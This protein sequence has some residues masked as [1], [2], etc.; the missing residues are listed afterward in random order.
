MRLLIY[1]DMMLNRKRLRKAFFKEYVGHLPA[2]LIPL[3]QKI[4]TLLLKNKKFRIIKSNQLD[5]K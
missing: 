4:K 5:Q 3:M 1:L 2:Q